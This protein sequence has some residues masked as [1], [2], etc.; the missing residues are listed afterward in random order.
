MKK[1]V[2][3]LIVTFLFLGIFTSCKK[4]KTVS[5]TDL[6]LYNL[7]KTTVG[8]TWYKNLDSLLAKSPS[9]GHAEPF[10]KTRYNAIAATKLDGTGKVQA[11]ADFPEGS[12]IV[13]ELFNNAT[14]IGRYA[15][16]YKNA[17]NKDADANGW[18]W[19]YVNADGTVNQPASNKG[20][21]CIN[22]HSQSD[23]IDYMLM[24]KYFP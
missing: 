5:N 9:S 22:C 15:I 17:T 11:G 3:F 2:K 16:L 12:L 1:I 18:V 7:S 6:E 19:G 8:F 20:S 21:A 14:T 10:L 4:D 13:K 23:N 24:N